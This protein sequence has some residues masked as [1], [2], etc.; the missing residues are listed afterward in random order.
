MFLRS[1]SHCAFGNQDLHLELRNRMCNFLKTLLQN[2]ALRTSIEWIAGLLFVG[3][4][5]DA[6]S[7]D[8]YVDYA[9]VPGVWGGRGEAILCSKVLNEPII[10]IFPMNGKKFA[11]IILP[12]DGWQV[13]NIYNYLYLQQ[14]IYFYFIIIKSSINRKKVL[15]EDDNY[16]GLFS[17]TIDGVV[18]NEKTIA[19]EYNGINHYE[20][21][22]FK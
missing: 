21:I 3:A 6:L 10:F 8:E 19:I 18:L 20:A 15:I 5:N 17:L 7:L 11:E 13:I 2:P 1:I 16:D 12:T 14:K 4:H 22:V 9:S